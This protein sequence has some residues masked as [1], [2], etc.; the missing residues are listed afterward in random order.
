MDSHDFMDPGTPLTDAATETPADAP[1]DR[2]ITVL[3]DPERGLFCLSVGGDEGPYLCPLGDDVSEV[4]YN[5]QTYQ[6]VCDL[7]DGPGEIEDRA[8]YTITVDGSEY[9]GPVT[10]AVVDF[11]DVE[12]EDAD[13]DA[14]EDVDEDDEENEEKED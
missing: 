6:A 14:D 1:D 3:V 4:I 11:G 9:D 8:D 7:E 2:D 12:D 10:L 13:E 5:G